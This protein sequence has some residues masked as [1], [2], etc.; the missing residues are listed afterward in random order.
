MYPSA[1]HFQNL[2]SRQVGFRAVSGILFCQYNTNTYTISWQNTL[3]IRPVDLLVKELLTLLSPAT[4][5]QPESALLHQQNQVRETLLTSYPEQNKPEIKSA[6]I[7]MSDMRGF[8]RF[9]EN[10]LPDEVISVLNRYFSKIVPI[11]ENYNGF[12]DKFIGDAIMAVFAAGSSQDVLNTLR[13]AV[14]IQNT[15]ES[16]NTEIAAE[17]SDVMHMGM[18]IDTGEVVAGVL[19]SQSYQEFT[20]I[21]SHVNLASRVESYS[22]PGQILISENTFS[23]CQENICIGSVYEVQPKGK[24]HTI[25]IF[26]L[27]SIGCTNPMYVPRLTRRKYVRATVNINIKFNIVDGKNIS[28]EVLDGV[29]VDISYTGIGMMTKTRLEPLTEIR[30][31]LSFSFLDPDL[32][33]IYAKTVRCTEKDGQFFVGVEFTSISNQAMDSIKALVDSRIT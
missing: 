4:L 10:K 33:E 29:A 18:G 5:K 19:G 23:Q 2:N 21:G 31:L 26:E 30:I 3:K 27:A 28:T 12:I 15:M 13:C 20:Y 7:L 9:S 32:S 8:T 24:D 6:S 14:E 16:I 17:G 25:Q 1:L 11:I 22:M